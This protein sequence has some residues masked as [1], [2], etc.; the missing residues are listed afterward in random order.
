MFPQDINPLNGS[1][2]NNASTQTCGI[3]TELYLDLLPHLWEALADSN[4][5]L[6]FKS[7]LLGFNPTFFSK[8]FNR[9]SVP[10]LQVLL[11]DPRIPDDDMEFVCP[12]WCMPL[13]KFL[14][15]ILFGPS[16]IDG[17]GAG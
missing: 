11:E 9:M 4:Q 14:R 6:N 1:F 15:V 17:D 13:V 7:T 12:F 10:E 3:I 16:A 5:R 2:H 8:T